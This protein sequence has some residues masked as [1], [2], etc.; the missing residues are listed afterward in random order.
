MSV[1]A[2][3]YTDGLALKAIDLVFKY[4][5]HIKMEMMK[6]QEKNA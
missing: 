4:L 1:M 3:D 2:N 5:E 6:K